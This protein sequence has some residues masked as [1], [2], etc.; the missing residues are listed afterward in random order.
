MARVNFDQ[1][2]AQFDQQVQDLLLAVEQA[3]WDLYGS[4]WILYVRDE[5]LKISLR[6]WNR[7]KQLFEAKQMTVQDLAQLEA[8]YQANRL[9]RLAAL[10][11]G[12]GRAGVLRAERVLRQ[13]IGLP[14]EDGTR[15]VPSDRPTDALYHPDWGTARDEALALRPE[16]LQARQQVKLAE[17]RVQQGRDALLPDLRFFSTYNYNGIG[18]RLDGPSSANAFESLASNRYH[19]WTLGLQMQVALGAREAN[20]QARNA[21]LQLGQSHAALRDGERAVIFGLQDSYR[22]LVEAAEA[23]R[24]QRALIATAQRQ[25]EA[26]VKEFQ[27][28]QGIVF[29]LLNAQQTW[30]GAQEQYQTAICFYN[31]ALANWQRQKGTILQY[32]NVTIAEGAVPPFA[33]ERASEHI[34]ERQHALVLRE[35]PAGSEQSSDL[36]PVK[37]TEPPS[38]PEFMAHDPGG[39]EPLGEA[40]PDR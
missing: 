2:R 9:Q 32:D 25:L 5:A 22:Q 26:R 37:I 34:H 36:L 7:G 40:L 15:L 23:L 39:F 31:V 10:G 33:A 18:T 4:Y 17:L 21:L 8:Q 24:M 3:Y 20:A 27:L 29:N 19:D 16:L 38:L 28:G 1:A 6:T 13:T 35:R 12:A 14:P 30:F 11:Q